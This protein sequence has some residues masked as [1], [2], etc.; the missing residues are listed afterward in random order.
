MDFSSVYVGFIGLFLPF[1][2]LVVNKGYKTV[3]LYLACYL[4]FSALYVLGNFYFFFG[5]SLKWISFFLNLHPFFFLIGPFSFFYFRSIVTD[6]NKLKKSDLLHFALFFISLAGLIPF[7]FSDADQ[8]LQVAVEMKSEHW[9]LAKY[10]INKLI[11]HKADQLICVV[12]TIFYSICNWVFVLNQHRRWKKNMLQV[13]QYKLIHKWLQTLSAI[14]SIIA[15][16]YF[17]VVA[18]IWIYDDK[19]EFLARANIFLLIASFLFMALNF[20]VLVFPQILYGLPQ[21]NKV[22]LDSN[23]IDDPQIVGSDKYLSQ[24]FSAEYINQIEKVLTEQVS[25]KK[26]T[27]PEYKLTLISNL[28]LIPLHHFSYY[29]N[30]IKN[31]SF[32][33]WRN[34]LRVNYAK[35]LIDNGLKFDVTLNVVAQKCGFSASSTFIRAFKQVTGKT[36]SEY[37]KKG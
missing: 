24:L 9:D 35:E 14:Y 4:F 23:Q 13:P 28:S 29:F 10:K 7:I 32:S 34:N 26:F 21:E 37:M 25:L 5:E 30:N 27:D 33:E 16:D 31:V 6:N 8:K 19:T 15:I 12:Q 20:A 3:N 22:E 11:P 18:C 36:P 1:L 17:I 2:I